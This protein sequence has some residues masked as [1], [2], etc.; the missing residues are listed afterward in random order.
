VKQQPKIAG[1]TCEM[2]Q[3]AIALRSVA[4]P[5]WSPGSTPETEIL[6]AADSEIFQFPTAT[7]FSDRTA[8]P[9]DDIFDGLSDAQ[10]A[11]LLAADVPA[12][13]TPAAPEH[14]KSE[15]AQRAAHGN[16]G[17]R[18]DDALDEHLRQC[19]S[20]QAE[21]TATSAFFRALAS[22]AGPEPSA[23]L[24]ARARQRLDATLDGCEHEGLWTQLTQRLAFTAGRM[25]AAPVLCSGLLF[26]G[27]LAGGYAGYHAG[28]SAHNAD[29]SALLLAPPATDAPSVVV[30][31]NSIAQDPQ[32][33]LVE[34]RYDRL[35][36]DVLTAP[37]NDPSIRELLM[38]GAQTGVS[39]MVRNAS[40]SLLS[41]DC[42][43]G[44]PC[45][46][47]SVRSALLNALETDKTPEVRREALAELQ[48]YIAD[49]MQ[50]RDAVLTALMRDPSAAV[51]IEAVRLLQPVDVDSSVRQ[52]LHTVAASDGDPSIRSASLAALKT[53]P[54]LQ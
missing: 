45:A 53:L 31:V 3:R 5:E 13:F 41:T 21:M 27:L 1:L 7:A 34:V 25:R 35:V 28:M 46:Q 19:R 17:T 20:C 37:L 29:Q 11:A 40:L 2:A 51:R 26:A 16:L 22:E 47:A 54:P 15:T 24:L 14:L 36:P 38:A 43:F 33:G 52:V 30:D 4:S 50:V 18:A 32:T 49:D 42:S 39:P 8:T 10:L 23:N 48:P 6:A 44:S 9:F 12:D